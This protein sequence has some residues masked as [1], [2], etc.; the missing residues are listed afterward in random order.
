[1]TNNDS[2]ATF[3]RG[4]KVTIEIRNAWHYGTTGRVLSVRNGI[5]SVGFDGKGTVHAPIAVVRHTR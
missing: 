2:L 4:D 3:T 1:M 5:V